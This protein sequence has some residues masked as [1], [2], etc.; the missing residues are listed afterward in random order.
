MFPVAVPT[1]TLAL[2]L[3]GVAAAAADPCAAIGGQTW[4]LPKDL[5]A[6]FEAQPVNVT[7][8][9]NVRP[10]FCFPTPSNHFHTEINVAMV[11]L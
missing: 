3:A 1:I 9:N 2:S 11:A 5:Q 8:K 4:V 6:C 7:E 10:L